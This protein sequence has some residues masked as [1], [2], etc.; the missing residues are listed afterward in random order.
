[1]SGSRSRAHQSGALHPLTIEEVAAL[2]EDWNSDSDASTVLLEEFSPRSP[3]WPQPAPEQSPAPTTTMDPL[4][5]YAEPIRLSEVDSSAGPIL[6]NPI[7]RIIRRERDRLKLMRNLKDQVARVHTMDLFDTKHQLHQLYWYVKN[8]VPALC[9]LSGL[10]PGLGE[11]ADFH[12]GLSLPGTTVWK[13][14]FLLEHLAWLV[15]Q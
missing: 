15:D 14:C 8:Q 1:M 5:G 13:V 11:A 3:G 6:T 2:Q 7:D 9:P 10:T 4:F 12:L